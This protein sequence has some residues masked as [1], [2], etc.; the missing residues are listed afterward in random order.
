MI[1]SL[2]VYI[3]SLEFVRFLHLNYEQETVIS[4]LSQSLTKIDALI[5][6]NIMRV[7]LHLST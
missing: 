5:G 7:F 4:Q 1:G 2:G 3:F 6:P